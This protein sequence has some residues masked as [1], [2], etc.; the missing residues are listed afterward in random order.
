MFAGATALADN[1]PVLQA[2]A[3]ELEATRLC[4]EQL[5]LV[6]CRNPELAQA[7]SAELQQ[8]DELGQ[9]QACLAK[10]LRAT[11][12]QTATAGISLDALRDSMLAKLTHDRGKVPSKC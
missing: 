6:L 10:V 2:I 4:L 8:L 5:G 12:M 3:D 1:L 7:H 11:D 9:R